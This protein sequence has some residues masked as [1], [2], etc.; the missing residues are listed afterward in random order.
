[1]TVAGGK[2][3]K[4]ADWM[5]GGVVGNVAWVVLVGAGGAF[6]GTVTGSFG[7][8]SEFAASHPEEAAV[9]SA[10]MF[11]GGA[12]IGAVVGA[13]V[14][15]RRKNKELEEARSGRSGA[16]TISADALYR[17]IRNLPD[18][19]KRALAS[20]FGNGGSVD[21]R[22]PDDDLLHLVREGLLNSPYKMTRSAE[23]IWSL[24]PGVNEF[25]RKHPDAIDGARETAE[26][27]ARTMFAGLSVKQCGLILRMY[28]KGSVESSMDSAMVGLRDMG[29]V[30]VGANGDLSGK[31]CTMSLTPK[32]TRAINE[33]PELFA[34][35]CRN[36]GIEIPRH[37]PAASEKPEP[38]GMRGINANFEGLKLVSKP[39]AKMVVAS[40]DSS[41]KPQPIEDE[42]EFDRATTACKGVV[43]R[44]RTVLFGGG[45]GDFTGKYN[46]YPEWI[47]FLDSSPKAVQF[48]RELSE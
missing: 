28:V 33:F 27:E 26:D 41:W 16:R 38:V 20:V 46:V 4:L 45:Y 36:N 13:G 12:L 31:P 10:L 42:D 11:V 39:V 3:S 47:R 5:V 19:Q 40:L 44:D 22:E 1:M 23:C 43:R 30:S 24:P 8:V 15:T 35:C 6:V 32:W 48:M 34:D 37:E 14:A 18:R 29:A 9:Y 17:K 21:V 25:L 2:L 7:V